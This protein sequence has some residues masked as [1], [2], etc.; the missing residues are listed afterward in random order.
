MNDISL[1]LPAIQ[2]DVAD[3]LSGFQY[4]HKGPAGIASNSINQ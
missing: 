4:E 2:L 1:T 3:T